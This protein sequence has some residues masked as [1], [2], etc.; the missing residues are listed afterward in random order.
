MKFIGFVKV[1]F[2]PSSFF[3]FLVVIGGNGAIA[4]R[5]S[6]VGPL[7]TQVL[8]WYLTLLC[9][10]GEALVLINK[11]GYF[12][13]SIWSVGICLLLL[14]LVIKCFFIYIC[15]AI[16][17]SLGAISVSS[18]C[19][20]IVCLVLSGAFWLNICISIKSYS[21]ITL[22]LGLNSFL[23]CSCKLDFSIYG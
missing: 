14:F 10:S 17:Y 1:L 20:C 12:L 18:L 13:I 3:L 5:K 19:D 2:P 23:L 15:E 22:I 8:L 6:K 21:L 4:G 9:S 16:Y 7:P 11:Q